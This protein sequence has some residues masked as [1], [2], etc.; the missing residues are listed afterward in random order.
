[1]EGKPKFAKRI[2]LKGFSYKGTYAYFITIACHGKQV[3]FID[4]ELVARTVDVLQ[5]AA[6]QTGFDIWAYCFMPDHLHLLVEGKYED[7]D[8]RRFVSLFKQKSA[9][10]C[11]KGRGRKLWQQNYYEHVLRE[12]EDIL[13][14]VR[15]IFENPVRKEIVRDYAIYPYLGSCMIEDIGA[16]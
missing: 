10:S 6:E 1:M 11:G 9:Y 16:M 3:Y 15:Y 13:G 14:V 7:A 4:G 5:T 12:E 2:R 8:M